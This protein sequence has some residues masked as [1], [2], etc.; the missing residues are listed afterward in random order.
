[1]VSERYPYRKSWRWYFV[2]LFDLIFD[3]FQKHFQSKGFPQAVQNIL[4]IRL[5]HIGDLICSLPVLPVL[6]RRFPSAEIT[7][8][9]GEEGKAILAGNPSID[10]LLAF[11]PNWFSRK[12]F[13]NLIQ[14]FKTICEL[15][16]TKYDL[17]FDLRGDLR[18]I[19]LMI[20]AGVR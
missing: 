12:R 16:K 7:V 11:V 10:H 18:N 19:I 1:M 2:R 13:V 5:D 6:K 3:P 20:L 14:F 4:I 15:R 17:G 8:L 9:T